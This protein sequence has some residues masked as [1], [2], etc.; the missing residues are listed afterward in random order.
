[1]ES[2]GPPGVEEEGGLTGVD[3]GWVEHGEADCQDKLDGR[4]G[5]EDAA[6]SLH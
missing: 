1:M 6:Y 4:D 3:G 5:S 2:K